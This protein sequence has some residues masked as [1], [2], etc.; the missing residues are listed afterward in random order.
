M[1][2]IDLET[3]VTKQDLKDVCRSVTAAFIVSLGVGALSAYLTTQ[4]NAQAI[5]TIKKEIS[6]IQDDVKREREIVRG[7]AADVAWIRGRLEG[8]TQ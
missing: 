8:R 6:D 3:S 1:A 2:S 4:A 5:V 7:M